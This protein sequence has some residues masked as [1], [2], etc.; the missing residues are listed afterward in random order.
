MDKKT[1]EEWSCDLFVKEGD[2]LL[3]AVAYDFQIVTFRSTTSNRKCMV[4]L[5]N[6]LAGKQLF[7]V[8]SM[9]SKNDS[10]ILL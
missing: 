10:V 6:S 2:R 8:A 9:S 3:V 7:L 5:A 4:R 1:I